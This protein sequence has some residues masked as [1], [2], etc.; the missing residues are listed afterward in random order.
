MKFCVD[1]CVCCWREAADWIF[2]QARVIGCVFVFDSAPPS[3]IWWASEAW[4]VWWKRV[5]FVQRFNKTQS[6]FQEVRIQI[7][8]NYVVVFSRRRMCSQSIIFGK[9]KKCFVIWTSKGME[10]SVC[11]EWNHISH[12]LTSLHFL[13]QN[14]VLWYVL[15]LYK[16]QGFYI[17][18]LI[19]LRNCSDVSIYWGVQIF[20]IL[21]IV[22]K[23]WNSISHVDWEIQKIISLLLDLI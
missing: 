9:K 19:R 10:S 5:W 8:I 22:I 23:I 1:G 15:C 11:T 16:K 13:W 2:W 6:C 4:R 21:L 3:D 18:G 14:I 17:G 20:D 7:K 12:M